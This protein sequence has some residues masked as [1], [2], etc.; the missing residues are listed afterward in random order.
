MQYIFILKIF[1]F[2][3]LD[4]NLLDAAASLSVLVLC[5]LAS[6]LGVTPLKVV[7]LSF[8]LILKGKF[9]LQNMYWTPAAEVYMRA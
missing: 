5:P 9:C 4:S 8:S 7:R 3:K 1:Y 6:H 2:N